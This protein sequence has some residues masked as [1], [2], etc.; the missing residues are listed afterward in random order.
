MSVD[1]REKMELQSCDPRD[2]QKAHDGEDY[3]V[4]NSTPP[5]LPATEQQLAQWNATRQDF[6]LDACVPQLAAKWG[7]T[8]PNAIAV[9]EGDRGL[10]YQ[11]LNQA[12]NQLAHYLQTLGV[13]PGVPVGF[14]VERDLHIIVGLLAI[15]KAGGA[16]VPLD[17]TYPAERL[18]FMLQD[19]QTPVLVTQQH[20]AERLSLQNV[21]V[22]CLDRDAGL[23]AQQSAAEPAYTA[24]VDDL[25]YIIYT[26]GSTGRPKGVEITHKSLLN[27]VC[28]HQQAFGVTTADRATQLTSP[29]FDA[30]GWELWPYLTA[31]ACIYMPTEDTRTAPTRLR[32]WLLDNKITITFLPTMLAESMLALEWPSSTPLRFM[33]TGADTLHHYPSPALP[34]TLV[35]NYGP[36]EA[37]VLVTSGP[38]P[39]TPDATTPPTIGRPI[40]NAQIYILDEQLR[41]VPVDT[42]GEL[43]IGGICLARGYLNRPELTAEKFIPNPF[44]GTRFTASD[45]DPTARLYKTGDLARFLPDG[46]IA[47]MGRIDHQVKIR[48]YRIEL[49]EIMAALNNHEAIQTSIVTAR[50][51]VAGDKRLVAYIV[52]TPEAQVTVSSLRE[53][54]LTHLPDYMVPATFVVLDMLPV[55][56]NGKIDRAALPVPDETNM[57]RDGSISVPTTPTE[58]RLA[59][60]VAPLLGL[61][62]IG[63]DENF[64]MLGGHSL[65]GTQIIMHVTTS[66]GVE[67]PLRTLFE[68]PTVRE[69]AAEIE[70]LIFVKINA[71]SDEEILQLLEQEQNA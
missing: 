1:K 42:P 68:A 37:T 40:A 9:V 38:V 31:G 35:N 27:L 46:Q 48:G 23:L 64:F 70:Q 61:Q 10:T 22:V 21:A 71:M 47:F 16:Y 69:L 24:T 49:D 62:Q 18:T 66:F 28:W 20:L 4:I 8:T 2:S 57:L 63:V 26:S 7:A 39:P 6:P 29:A 11:E 51:D 50:E 14:C 67:L 12:A 32:D 53:A 13:E 5:Q 59:A 15:L 25:A 44:V 52:L 17:P 36:S 45:L 41:Q 58:E 60:I 56:P 34:F 55:T 33:L 54:L 3:Q 30:T 65:L 19:S 43:H